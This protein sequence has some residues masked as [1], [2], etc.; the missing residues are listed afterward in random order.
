M[1]PFA[2]PR[3]GSARCSSAHFFVMPRDGFVSRGSD[4]L[5]Q[6][7]HFGPGTLLGSKMGPEK[8]DFAMK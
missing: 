7:Q 3:A 1:A 2:I 6:G 5:I 8:S 4:F